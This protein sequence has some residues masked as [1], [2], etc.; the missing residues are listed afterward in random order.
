[1]FPIEANIAPRRL[2]ADGPCSVL[3]R[4]VLKNGTHAEL[5]T[6]GNDMK[7]IP[8]LAAAALA[9]CSPAAQESAETE[10]TSASER[11]VNVY[12]ARHYSSDAVV[13]TAFTEATGISVNLIEANG[14]QLIARIRA[15]G[16]RSPADVVITVDAARLHR[17]EQAGLF[18]QTDFSAY[19]D[20]VPAHLIDPDRYWISF[21]KRARVIAYSPDRVG[22]DEIATYADLADPRWDDRICIRN[23]G[24]AYNQSLL[25]SIIAQSGDDSAENWAAA[26]VENMA[27]APQGGDRD[28]LRGIAAGECDVAVVNHYYYAMLA[29]SGDEADRNAAAASVLHFPSEANGGAHVNVSGAGVAVNAPHPEEAMALIDFLLSNEAQRIFAEESNEIPVVADAIWDND[30]LDAMLP[31][32]EDTRNVSELGDHNAAA[33]RIFDRVGWP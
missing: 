22:A 9:A 23:S 25:A 5:V 11:V 13:Y 14:D 24:N 2:A 3:L 17:A 26:I 20:R 4:N 33:Q 12:S 21:A 7:F 18:A 32:A 10:D 15:D 19:S 27:R 1:V 28:Q 16:A 30:V 31:F 8:I 6:I 29:N